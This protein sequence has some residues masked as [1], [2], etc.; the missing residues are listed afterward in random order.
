MI[1]ILKK[2][3]DNDIKQIKDAWNNMDTLSHLLVVLFVTLIF[4]TTDM[5]A[6]RIHF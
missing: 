4:M 3:I 6:H 1:K 5:I 2:H